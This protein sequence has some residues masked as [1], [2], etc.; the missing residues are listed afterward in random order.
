MRH[1]PSG[2]LRSKAVVPWFFSRTMFVAG[3]T[4]KSNRS[5]VS[6]PYPNRRNTSRD[7]VP[8]RSTRSSVG[9]R[10]TTSNMKMPI[11]TPWNSS[12]RRVRMSATSSRCTSGLAMRDPSRGDGGR[13]FRFARAGER[14]ESLFQIGLF[15]A[16]LRDLNSPLDQLRQDLSQLGLGDCRP[17]ADGFLG[18]RFD[19]L[20]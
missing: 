18:G 6:S 13:R 14:H 20:G 10:T 16:K 1:A 9:Q 12:I 11:N 19:H 5:V 8:D 15:L 3:N 4:G 17:E 2:V 7:L